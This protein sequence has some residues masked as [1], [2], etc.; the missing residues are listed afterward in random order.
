MP[1]SGTRPRWPATSCW[2]CWRPST[3]PTVGWTSPRRVG[4]R[5]PDPAAGRRGWFLLG[6]GDPSGVLFAPCAHEDDDGE[7]DEGDDERPQGREDPGEAAD[8]DEAAGQL[9]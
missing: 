7:G 9:R 1:R 8:D 5:P 2:R 3:C 6:G 4:C